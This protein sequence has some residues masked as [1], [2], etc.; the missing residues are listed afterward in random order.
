M[1]TPE[2][3]A[4]VEEARRAFEAI[5]ASRENALEKRAALERYLALRDG[6][7]PPRPTLPRPI[8]FKRF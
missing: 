7:R 4:R 8:G 3:E 1:R 2:L 5:P 6:V